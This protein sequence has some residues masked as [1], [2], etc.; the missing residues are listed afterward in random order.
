MEYKVRYK[1][2]GRRVKGVLTLGQEHIS[3]VPEKEGKE[4]VDIHYAEIKKVKRYTALDMVL[5]IIFFPLV[6][7]AI[8]SKSSIGV[9]SRNKVVV[10][11]QDNKK[12]VFWT[13]GLN[14]RWSAFSIVRSLRKNIRKTA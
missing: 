4:Y 7:I 14:F 1:S 11:T 3:F 5:L 2:E 10:V 13:R 8:F 6:L 12:Y 9:F